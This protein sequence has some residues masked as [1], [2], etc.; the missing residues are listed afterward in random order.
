M[1][2][3]LKNYRA[4]IGYYYRAVIVDFYWALIG[5][6]AVIGAITDHLQSLTNNF[7]TIR[8]PWIA[9]RAELVCE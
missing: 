3:I 5:D 8:I 6:S 7:T 1:N 9:S 2:V 4:V